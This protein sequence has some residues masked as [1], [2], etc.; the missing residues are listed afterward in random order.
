MPFRRP[1]LRCLLLALL[2]GGVGGTARAAE[3]A[4]FD[5]TVAGFRAGTM[6]LAT[7]RDASTYSGRAKV[8]AAGVVGAFVTFTYDA[9]ANGAVTA[10]G[11]VVPTRFDANSVSPGNAHKTTILWKGGVPT[12]V[13]ITPP[14]DD[15]PNP[16]EQGGT[17]DPVSAAVKMLSDGP[18][19]QRC[20]M[21]VTVFDGS[22]L[23]RLALGPRKPSGSG[24]TCAGSYARVKGVAASISSLRE[25]PFTLTFSQAGGIAKL[26]RIETSTSFGK[27]VLSRKG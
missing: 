22:R 24:F 14:R 19:E 18:V 20:D 8:N 17:L 10:K 12:S 27:A 7:T 3:T 26:Q 2:L 5:L 16:A 9:T 15:V 11:G 25:F 1:L 21:V 6:S 4:S 13:T 23:S